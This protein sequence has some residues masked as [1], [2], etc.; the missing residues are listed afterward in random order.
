MKTPISSFGFRTFNA[1]QTCP[2]LKVR[3]SA[4]GHGFVRPRSLGDVHADCLQC[5]EHEVCLLVK[6]K[7]R[8]L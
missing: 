8:A 2:A 3:G 4:G 6:K 5:G 7:T 1:I